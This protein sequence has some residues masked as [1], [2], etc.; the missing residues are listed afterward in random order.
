MNKKLIFFFLLSVVVAVFINIVAGG[1]ISAKL[2]SV[3]FF[4]KY[5]ILNPQAPIVIT[6]REEAKAGDSVDMLDAVNKAKSR[7]SSVASI[8]SNSMSVTGSA[9]NLSADG[10]FLT[11]QATLGNYPPANL[12]IILNNGQHAPIV[13]A[14]GDPGSN[15][16]I[17]K[18]DLS[19]VPVTEF[20]SS[21]AMA[22][23]QKIG[24][25]HSLGSTTGEVSFQE[26]YVTFAQK[27]NAGP[28]FQS[29]KPARSFGAQP[30]GSFV[31][32]EVIINLD[33]KVI[34]M[35]DGKALVS[36][37]VINETVRMFFAGERKLIPRPLW[38]FA[39]RNIGNTESGLFQLPLGVLVVGVE[40]SG[41]AANAGLKA[42]DSI[43][44][45]GGQAISEDTSLEELLQQQKPAQSIA[46]TVVRDKKLITIMVTPGN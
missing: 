16:V 26:S 42:G 13:F 30:V 41:S 4:E 23:A 43:T 21:K 5:H 9:I 11:T 33:G 35:W 39:Y 6:R 17:V 24:F 46:F 1:W 22:P 29:D 15:L 25:V 19:N 12:T 2:S 34:G 20:S 37:D 8:A 27:S 36:S 40:P 38:R 32:G 14:T 45:V 3:P 44:A 28:I 7:L 31:P 18:A 10:Y